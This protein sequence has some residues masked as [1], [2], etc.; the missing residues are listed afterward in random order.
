MHSA[1]NKR[2]GDGSV[3]E[4]NRPFCVYLLALRRQTIRVIIPANMIT[5]SA[6]MNIGHLPNVS[7]TSVELRM[8]RARHNENTWSP[9]RRRPFSSVFNLNILL[10][11]A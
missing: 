2:K 4:Q 11:K 7:V 5:G 1:D 10:T 6:N 3:R 9:Q 8:V